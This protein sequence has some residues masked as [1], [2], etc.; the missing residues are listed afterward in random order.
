MDTRLANMEDLVFQAMFLGARTED[1]VY[2][3]V[4]MRDD[5]ADR[6]TV[7]NIMAEFYTDSLDTSSAAS[8][9]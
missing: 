6:L 3:Y 7:K 2:P 5:R 4:Y 8:Y 9:N 1:E